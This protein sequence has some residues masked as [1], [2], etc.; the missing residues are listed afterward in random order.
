MYFMLVA[1]DTSHPL[2]SSLKVKWHGALCGM[3]DRSVIW[4]VFQVEMWPWVASAAVGLLHH[5]F[6][7]D[8]RLVLFNGGAGAWERDISSA[9]TRARETGPRE[10]GRIKDGT[11]M[12]AV[13]ARAHGPAARPHS[14]SA[15]RRA[16]E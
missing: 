9:W 3:L 8:A 1:W 13:L 14:S 15:T 7:A 16:G 6:R 11:S 2:M 4:L 10:R 5:S 12:R